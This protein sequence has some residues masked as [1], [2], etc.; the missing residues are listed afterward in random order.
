[1][2]DAILLDERRAAE[3][4]GLSPRYLQLC[5][6]RNTGPAY[7]RI[8]GRTIRY[9]PEDLRAWAEAHLCVPEGGEAA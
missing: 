4:I 9:R 1:M 2:G 5:R 8:S 7:V 3:L 6:Q